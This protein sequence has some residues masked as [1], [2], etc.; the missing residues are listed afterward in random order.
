MAEQYIT[1][2]HCGKRIQLTEAFTHDI[3]ERLR[4]EFD[5]EAKRKEKEFEKAFEAQQKEYEAKLDRERTKLINQAKKEAEELVSTELADLKSEV[6]KKENQLKEARKKE[7]EL[8][9]KQH[10]IDEREKSIELEIERTLARERKKIWEEAASKAVEEHQLKDREKDEQ[11]A[12]MRKQIEELKRKAEQ[13]SQ[14]AQGEALELELEEL[15]R[16]S[17]RTDDIEPVSKGVRGG[18]VIHRVNTS[19]GSR[20]GSILWEAKRTKAWSDVWIDKLKDDQRQGKFDLAVIVSS[21]LPKGINRSGNVDGV[22][23]TDFQSVIG[24]ATALR[25]LL[26]E[27]YQARNALVGKSEKMEIIYKY[28]SG[29]EFR[30]RVEAIVEAFVAMKEDLEAEKRAMEKVW[31]KREKQIQRVI[32]NTAGMY[33]DLQGIIGAS[34]PE[35]KI[36]QLPG[37]DNSELD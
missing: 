29:S 23:V 35:I 21:V 1:C 37:S 28:L 30:H 6:E 24:L 15:L 3:E 10:E 11:L 27:V 12:E 31:S 26:I 16:S 18:D 33:G 7:L 8:L 5:L 19:S 34:L 13:G 20:C 14:Q 4:K 2:P 17:F 32:H 36:L 22:W 9:R 25:A